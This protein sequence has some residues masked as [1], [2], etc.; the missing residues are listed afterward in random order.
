[1]LWVVGER[2][3]RGL[4]PPR[5]A[6]P[7]NRI[8]AGAAGVTFYGLLWAASA[9]DQLA[10]HLHLDLYTVTWTFR[11]L[12]LAGPALAFLLTR[13]ICHALAGQ[14][15]EE[16]LH[17]RETGRI[18]RNPQGGY[19]EIR[20]P[21][22]RAAPPGADPPGPATAAGTLPRHPALHRPDSLA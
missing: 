12:V 13:A 2:P 8:A 6:D 5:P 10:Y 16:Q 19:D 20:E 7:A 18:V 1:D 14:R 9:N 22:H 3:P 15:R 11:V 21:A 17:G 4:L